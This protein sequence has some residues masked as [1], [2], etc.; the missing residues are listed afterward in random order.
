MSSQLPCRWFITSCDAAHHPFNKQRNERAKH[1]L[2]CG[3]RASAVFKVINFIPTTLRH[4]QLR[5]GH[6]HLCVDAFP[7]IFP[8]IISDTLLKHPI[9]ISVSKYARDSYIL[10]THSK[11]GLL[12]GSSTLNVCCSIKPLN[13]I[14]FC[15]YA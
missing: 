6:K 8:S 15:W 1:G 7:P 14:L 12:C 13:I 5:M 4:Q 2:T 11:W 3:R 10:S 9:V